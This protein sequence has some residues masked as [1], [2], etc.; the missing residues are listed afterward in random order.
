MIW[1]LFRLR[2][3]RGQLYPPTGVKRHFS[4][5]TCFTCGQ[6]GHTSTAC[7]KKGMPIAGPPA[8]SAKAKTPPEESV[9]FICGK[10]DH[11]F[12][13]CSLKMSP[14][15]DDAKS[16][17][18]GDKAS[19]CGTMGHHTKE[20]H[21]EIQVN[22]RY[23]NCLLDTGSDVTIFP[24]AMI[25]GRKLQPTTTTLMAANRCTLEVAEQQRREQTASASRM[26]QGKASGTVFDAGAIWSVVLPARKADISGTTHE[27]T[28]AVSTINKI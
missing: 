18:K 12:R 19:S 2:I 24:Y 11:L 4:K 22:G 15:T 23:Y 14:A 6:K 10:K 25:N 9:C 26:D 28:G 3:E 16:P 13:N 7:W 1:L 21:V 20:A 5:I 27:T 8:E 17:P